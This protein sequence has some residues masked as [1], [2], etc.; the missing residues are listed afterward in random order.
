M[1]KGARTREQNVGKKE[2]AKQLKIVEEHKKK[3][4]KL[5]AIVTSLVLVV[6][7]A[8]SSLVYTFYYANGTYLRKNV[9]ISTENFEIDNTMMTYLA[10]TSYVSMQETYGDYFSMF[11]GIDTSLSLKKQYYDEDSGTTWFDYIISQ[12]QSTVEN[13]L[14]LSEAA[15]D[16]GIELNDAELEYVESYLDLL[17]DY[18]L[19]EGVSKSDVRELLQISM[20]AQSYVN[21]AY[22]DFTYTDDEILEYY[23]A[24]ANYY[25]DVSYRYYT[26]YYSTTDEEGYYTQDEA[27]AIVEQL[28]ATSDPDEFAE[29]LSAMLL[30]EDSELTDEE[31]ESVISTT[32][33]EGGSYT[34]DD[35]LSEWVFGSSISIG[36][37]YTI[38][39]E[40][41]ETYKV[42]SVVAPA[43]KSEASTV[44]I[45]SIIFS[46]DFYMSAVV[47]NLYAQEIYDMYLENPTEEYFAE[48]ANTYTQDATTLSSGGLYLGVQCENVTDDMVSWLFEE[49]RTAG[50]TTMIETDYG[51]VLIYYID[52]GGTEWEENVIIDLQS[53]DYST[54]LTDLTALTTIT[55]DYTH[56]TDIPI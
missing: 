4:H 45:R 54:L 5:V 19:T 37:T 11:T 50:D 24:N 8:A 15:L 46:E 17:D 28:E 32:L 14:I 29:L 22:E 3:T 16:A 48:L 10:K 42:Y 13:L 40:T 20:L 36:D 56:I 31:I 38:Q 12:A 53:A 7:I 27:E 43:A 25:K 39:D 47:R 49:E 23:N 18:Y 35:E 33:V 1:G 41:Y 21:Y 55:Y 9:V 30:E 34:A 52:E 6:L 26:I 44:N 2:A 51:T